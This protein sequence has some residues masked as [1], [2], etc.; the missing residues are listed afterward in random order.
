MFWNFRGEIVEHFARRGHQVAVVVPRTAEAA[1]VPNWL[2]VIAA[3]MNPSS[4][5]PFNDI[6]Y[7]WQLIGILHRENPDIVFNYTI[8]PNIY[9]ALAARA[10]HVPAVDMVAGLGY[11]FDGKSLKKRLAQQLYKLGLR[12]A[13]R[14]ITLNRE[15]MSCL[16]NLGI[17]RLI[18]FEG[19][20][21]VNLTN[22]CNTTANNF[23][24]VHFLMVARVLREKGYFEFVEAAREVKRSYPEVSIEL[25]GGMACDSPM[26]ISEQQ[27]QSDLAEGNF[28]WL[29]T[30]ADVRPLLGKC[31]TVM[32][33]P[34]YHEGMS[35]SLMEACAMGCPIITSDI[36]GCREA[37]NEGEN[38]YLVP[39]RC[40]TSLANAMLRFMSLSEQEKCAMSKASRS[41]AEA[42][43]NI[44]HVI[45]NYDNIITDL[46]N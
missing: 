22:Y 29:G 24:Q 16:K 36:P 8:K 37:V 2:E 43:F 12:S 40:A 1:A 18:L 42:T 30:T 28:N 32:V 27:L 6:V 21:G 20:E 23:S 34:S 19:G 33:L 17:K 35:R 3:D 15:N 38:G 7:L 25:L 31:G 10:T 26:G 4:S 46:L 5:N 45:R 41:K 14:V 9:G 11:V 39:P 13:K 44:N